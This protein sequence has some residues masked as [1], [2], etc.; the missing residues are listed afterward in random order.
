M[1]AAGSEARGRRLHSRAGGSERGAPAGRTAERR[2]RQAAQSRTDAVRPI[3]AL[4]FGASGL[5]LQTRHLAEPCALGGPWA[6]ALGRSRAGPGRGKAP[7][8]QSPAG[9][10]AAP[11]SSPD[12]R[13]QRGSLGEGCSPWLQTRP[14][15]MLTLSCILSAHKYHTG[16]CAQSNTKTIQKPTNGN[17]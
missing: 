6:G 10:Y 3:H 9:A 8:L 2:G 14:A 11:L 16:K 12:A 1:N 4:G 5:A 17:G 7:R 13:V 15:H